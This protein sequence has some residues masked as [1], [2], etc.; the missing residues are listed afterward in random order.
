MGQAGRPQADLEDEAADGSGAAAL[1]GFG[2]NVGIGWLDAEFA[3]DASIVNTSTNLQQLVPKGSDLVFS[4]E[5]TLSAGIDYTFVLGNGRLVPR[6]QWGHIAEQ[7]ATPF[8][9]VATTVPSRS[10]WDARLTWE[11]GNWAVEAF[12]TNISDK[13]YIASQ[14]PNSTSATGGIVY[15]APQQYGARVKFNFGN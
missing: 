12:M 2:V 10:L 11:Q 6:L 1:G 14:I 15:G 4:P 8:P 7:L 5:W 13:T 3:E 9:S